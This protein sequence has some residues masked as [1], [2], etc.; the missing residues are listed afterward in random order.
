[1][2]MAAV[3]SIAVL[4]VTDP[5][6]PCAKGPAN[7]TTTTQF[8]DL[9]LYRNDLRG[10]WHVL[11][12]K[13]VPVPAV[14]L[15]RLP[16]ARNVSARPSQISLLP[17]TRPSLPCQETVSPSAPISASLPVTTGCLRER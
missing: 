17:L 1:M 7:F 6:V 11:N 2:T 14:V 9:C 10:G 13:D 12:A 15:P 5:H 4:L 16:A 8:L 3:N